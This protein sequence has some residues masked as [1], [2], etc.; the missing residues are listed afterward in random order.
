MLLAATLTIGF[1]GVMNVS[2][3]FNTTKISYDFSFN[4]SDYTIRRVKKR[5]ITSIK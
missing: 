5:Y 4:T 1:I 2:V 3:A